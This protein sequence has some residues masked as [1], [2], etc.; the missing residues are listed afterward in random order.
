MTMTRSWTFT[1]LEFKS[2]KYNSQ[3][4]DAERFEIILFSSR[5]HEAINVLFVLER[6]VPSLKKFTNFSNMYA[7]NVCNANMIIIYL[8]M[9]CRHMYE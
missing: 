8:Q 2:L 5:L 3:I 7:V 4:S 6:Y 1:P 9:L